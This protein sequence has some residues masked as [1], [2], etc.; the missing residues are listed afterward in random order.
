MNTRTNARAAKEKKRGE[1]ISKEWTT[2]EL[3]TTP[4]IILNTLPTKVRPFS[5]F[6][7]AAAAAA[8]AAA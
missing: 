7:S 1:M 4:P 3:G 2:G 6:P 5:S 8:A